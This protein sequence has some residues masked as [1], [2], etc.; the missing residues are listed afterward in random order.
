LKHH[1]D[2]RVT[3]PK[4]FV[5]AYAKFVES[6]WNGLRFDP[7]FGGQGLPKLVD[8]AVMEMWNASNMAFSMA[9][10][11]TQGAIEALFLR[12]SDDQKQRFLH[13]MV[14]GEWT[15]TMN[16]TEPQAGSDFGP[17][18]QQGHAPRRPLPDPGPEDLHQLRRARPHRQHRPPGARAHAHGARGRQGHLAVPGA[19]VPRQRRRLARRAQRR[20]LRVDRTQ[21]GHPRQPDRGARVRRRPVARSAT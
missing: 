17:D 14:S 11:L 20:A 10:L 19:E 1:D 9:P 12:G 18:P 4:G 6:G 15:G 13:K 3:T 8:T 21:D 7:D 16:L 2:G 5:E